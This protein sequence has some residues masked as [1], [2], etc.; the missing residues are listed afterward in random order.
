[1][2]QL[3]SR[4]HAA[5]LV[6]GDEILSGKFMDTNT[7]FLAR[8]LRSVG[9]E[10]KLVVV[11]PDEEPRIVEEVQR[12]QRQ[13][14]LI[15]TSGGIGPTHDD[16]TYAAIAA[17]FQRPL[18][19]DE[20]TLSAMADFFQENPVQADRA[21]MALI[22]SGAEVVRT[23]GLWVPLT[24]VNGVHILPG[25]PWLFQQMISHHLPRWDSGWRCHVRYLYTHEAEGDIA[26]RLRSIETASVKVGSY[27][28]GKMGEGPLNCV[29]VESWSEEDANVAA[30]KLSA[31]L[32]DVE[33]HTRNVLQ[34]TTAP[35]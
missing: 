11:V 14:P 22:P 23:P 7:Q 28:R 9:V 24:I 30:S 18:T 1:M 10:L 35:A 29:T 26:Q 25:V 2:R 5:F 3:E 13:F 12:I 32:G 33:V 31:L 6:I 21:R 4:T 17:A 8:S 20:E 19:Y 15:F 16:I 34:E 27:P